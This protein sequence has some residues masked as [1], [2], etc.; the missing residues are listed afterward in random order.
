MDG[1]MI[2]SLIGGQRGAWMDLFAHRID[3]T[4]NAR[5]IAKRCVYYTLVFF[6]KRRSH[7]FISLFSAVVVGYITVF[8]YDDLPQHRL[9]PDWFGWRCDAQLE[10]AHLHM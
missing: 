4:V 7:G 5:K 10:A 8:C 1:T 6:Y 2:E 9:L 3:T